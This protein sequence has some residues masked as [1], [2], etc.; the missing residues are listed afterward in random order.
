MIPRL[1]P[2]R[3]RDS[4][5]RVEYEMRDSSY[6]QPAQ[7]KSWDEHEQEKIHK[8]SGTERVAGSWS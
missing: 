1:V 8:R 5:I 4:L 6:S 3:M 2:S 7:K